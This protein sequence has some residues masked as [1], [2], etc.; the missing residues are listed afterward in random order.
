VRIITIHVFIIVTATLFSATTY[1]V[2][3]SSILQASERYLPKV[4][5]NLK[6]IVKAD[7]NCDGNDDFALTGHDK[8]AVWVA[9]FTDGLKSKPSTL[10]FPKAMLCSTHY[11]LNLESQDVSKTEMESMVGESPEGFQSSKKCKGLNLNHGD[12]DSIHIFWNHRKQS[13]DSWRL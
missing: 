9:V 2:E 3:V 10:S 4:K 11:N 7:I 12:C 8:K 13:L 6:S 5:W 1:A